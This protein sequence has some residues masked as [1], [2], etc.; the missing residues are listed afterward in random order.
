MK[1]FKK[2]F[3]VLIAFGLILQYRG[4][5]Y[6]FA[7]TQDNEVPIVEDIDNKDDEDKVVDDSV[8]K[9][10]L[11]D[12]KDL[13][14]ESEVPVSAEAVLGDFILTFKD[15]KEELAQEAYVLTGKGT[16]GVITYNLIGE[17]PVMANT[18]AFRLKFPLGSDVKLP[19]NNN[20]KL[21]F[22][23]EFD[24]KGV[25]GEND[26][27]TYVWFTLIS[28]INNAHTETIT[29]NHVPDLPVGQ[30]GTDD[31]V[32]NIEMDA[33]ALDGSS[34][35]KL[36]KSNKA[37][38]ISYANEFSFNTVSSNYNLRNQVVTTK[39]F[40]DLQPIIFRQTVTPRNTS[41]VPGLV[42]T[43]KI[44]YTNTFTVDSSTDNNPYIKFKRNDILKLNG[45]TFN[46]SELD[47]S[48]NSQ[49]HVYKF[50]IITEVFAKD[51]EQ[52]TNQPAEF[53]ITNAKLDKDLVQNDFNLAV[54]RS[55]KVLIKNTKNLVS[56]ILY[57]KYLV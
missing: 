50:T 46:N 30:L 15:Y 14:D 37:K 36:N 31:K 17:D 42:H 47:V 5:G 27:F 11:E 19:E 2:I 13:T 38:I 3:F 23:S 34:V 51:G 33:F 55:K 28:T 48:T 45:E 29:F 24:P 32:I 4:S 44:T 41:N 54:G 25:A 35:T 8:E 12:N 57:L 6:L 43:K 7:Q 9:K 1:N 52:L 26:E 10:E 53:E 20:Y 56:L 39:T 49:G 21:S 22:G 18:L 40:G 16:T